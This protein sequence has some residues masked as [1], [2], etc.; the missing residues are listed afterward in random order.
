MADNDRISHPYSD[1][2]YQHYHRSIA[3]QTNT[4]KIQK[5]GTC[6]HVSSNMRD[7]QLRLSNHVSIDPTTTYR[8]SDLQ[9]LSA[10]AQQTPHRPRR[11]TT[12]T[13]VK[14]QFFPLF[15]F[16]LVTWTMCMPIL[17][18]QQGPPI[19]IGTKCI[20]ITWNQHRPPILH[21]TQ[22]RQSKI[23]ISPPLPPAPSLSPAI[24]MH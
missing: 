9:T 20:M 3:T 15:P 21:C 24:D 18:N 19:A 14:L 11:R 10:T 7:R 5:H 13:Y 16:T 23:Q 4:F 1:I 6:V 2:A 22:E 8:L 12:C 17:G